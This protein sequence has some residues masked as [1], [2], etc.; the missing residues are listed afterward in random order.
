MNTVPRRS[1]VI[2]LAVCLAAGGIPV[3]LWA[4]PPSKPGLGGLHFFSR[5]KTNSPP[6]ESK[7]PPRGSQG[8]APIRQKPTTAP[9]GP[10]AK[11]SSNPLRQALD[12]VTGKSPPQVGHALQ[13]VP[14]TAAPS[15]QA[16]TTAPVA[17][18]TGGRHHNH[19]ADQPPP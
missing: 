7:S 11:G 14:T 5:S 17:P 6:V 12:R 19:G 10:S 8:L 2:A 9:V 16:P 15:N 3:P 13:P 18:P 4:A 1:L